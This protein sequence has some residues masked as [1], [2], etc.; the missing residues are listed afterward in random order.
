MKQAN[1]TSTGIRTVTAPD[2]TA[3]AYAEYGDP[4]ATPIVFLHGLGDSRL[5]RHPDDG[6][7][8]SLGVRLITIDAPGVGAS[9]RVPVRTHLEGAERV[10]AVA[11]ALSLDRFAVLG[12]SAGGPRAL[13]VAVRFPDR[14]RAVGVAAGFGPLSRPEVRA[15]ASKQIRQGANLLSKMPWMAN[16]FVASLPRAYRKDARAAF[17]KQFGAHASPADRALLERPEIRA[18]MLAGARESMRRGAKGMALEMQLLMARPWGFEPE[19]VGVPAHLFY[20]TDDRIVP[21]AMG[22]QLAGLLPHATLHTFEGEGHMAVFEHWAD[23]LRTLGA[24]A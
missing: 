15:L 18:M 17:E 9:D 12:W 13:A 22:R 4:A 1:D 10:M 5:T 2:G 21:E 19:D 7:T 23:I 14:V 11:D 8:N 6:L 3:I 16:L 24:A 20:G